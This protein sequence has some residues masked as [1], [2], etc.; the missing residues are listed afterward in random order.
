LENV[1][2]ID[3]IEEL[4][5]RFLNNVLDKYKDETELLNIKTKINK[6]SLL[7]DNVKD[8]RGNKNIILRVRT[9]VED[10]QQIQDRHISL[11]DLLSGIFVRIIK[12]EEI[13]NQVKENL[14]EQ[15]EGNATKDDIANLTSDYY[16]NK[17]L[18]YKAK[19]Q[20]LS[21]RLN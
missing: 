9:K 6:I 18:K 8:E 1:K 4:N 20:Q 12:Y 14:P 5:L 21:Q 3:L 7:T 2:T 17:Y 19:Y 10:Q 16:R 13:V 15:I 11:N